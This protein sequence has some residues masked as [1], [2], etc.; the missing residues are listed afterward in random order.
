MKAFDYHAPDTLDEALSLLD[1]YG[2]DATLIAGG[3]ALVL[4]MKQRL[5]QPEHLVSLGRVRELSGI[6][7]SNG[8]IR[9]GAMTTHRDVETSPLVA[10]AA[11]LLAKTYGHVATPRIRN[12]ATVGG[13]LVHADP[14]LDPPPGLIALG[15]RVTLASS[16]GER[17]IPIEDLFLDYY[18]TSLMPGEIVT[19]VDV[20]LPGPNTGGAFAKFLPRTADDYATVLA[21]ATITLSEDGTTCREVRIG[22]GSVG[23]TPIRATGAEEVLRG[24]EPSPDLIRRAAEAVEPQVDPLDDFRGSAGYKTR[25]AV[26]FTRRVLEQALADARGLTPSTGTF[27]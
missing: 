19:R 2:E 1:R 21:S 12:V 7:R 6:F 8:D 17:A 18:E 5:V 16:S 25:M 14:N 15:A 27:A 3:T 4:F 10:E 11:P 20:P 13:G 22:L 23:V 9:L 26:V 24:R